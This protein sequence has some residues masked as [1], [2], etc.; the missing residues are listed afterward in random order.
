MANSFLGNIGIT[1]Q[2]DV[3]LIQTL[4]S[5]LV[6][7]GNLEKTA[8]D[9]SLSISGL[10]YRINK[11]EEILQKDLRSP[12]ISYQLLLSIQA[13]IILGDLELKSN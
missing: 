12:L 13:L 11:L 5:F 2:K 9:L 6:N 1:C 7:G 10:R 8:D 3:D 4:Y